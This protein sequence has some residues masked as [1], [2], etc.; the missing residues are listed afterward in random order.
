M[1]KKVWLD[2]GIAIIFLLA[3]I[4][5][6]RH[7]DLFGVQADVVFIFLLWMMSCRGRS[8]TLVFAAFSSL[9][10]DILLDTWGLH[11]FAKTLTV[12]LAYN[13]INSVSESILQSGK[14]FTV[15]FLAA[16]LYYLIFLT[17]AVFAGKYVFELFFL[18]HWIGNSL[19]TAIIASLLYMLKP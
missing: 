3:Q 19:Y 11:L 16:L 14:V 6:F 17:M 10:L 8:Y 2:I 18:K 5:V 7:L 9:L 4:M 15:T 1:K 13:V 12:M